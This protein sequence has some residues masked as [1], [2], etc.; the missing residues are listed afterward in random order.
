MS[1]ARLNCICFKCM[2]V[3]RRFC[4]GGEIKPPSVCPVCNKEM[5]PIATY[6]RVPKRDRKKWDS[7][8]DLLIAIPYYKEL[9]FKTQCA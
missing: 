7:F 9:Y 3:S 8:F 5:M 2:K 6:W 4:T 1:N